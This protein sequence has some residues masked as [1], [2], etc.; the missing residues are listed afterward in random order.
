MVGRI[1]L[2][3]AGV[4]GVALLVGLNNQQRI[5]AAKRD[6]P[7]DRKEVELF[8]AR[9]REVNASGVMNAFRAAHASLIRKTWYMED[10]HLSNSDIRSLD[11][12]KARRNAKEI[13]LEGNVRLLR[14]DGALYEARRVRYDLVHKIFR[15]VGPFTAHR[16][17]D[18]ARGI[19][20][21]YEV[22]PR[23]TLA[24]EIFARYRLRPGDRTP[25]AK[26]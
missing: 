5:L 11:A 9:I 21:V 17:P 22:I 10:F 23:R 7:R 19:D 8:R 16:G 20:F 25:R 1:E 24:K 12:R 3:L 14:S 4:L 15:S 18:F 6:L 13:A 26:E 2:I